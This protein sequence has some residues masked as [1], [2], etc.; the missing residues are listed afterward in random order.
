MK[1]ALIVRRDAEEDIDQAFT[2]YESQRPG[3][4]HDFLLCVEAAILADGSS[5]SPEKAEIR[6]LH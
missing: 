1:R 4:G 5:A 2:W 6:N 3:L